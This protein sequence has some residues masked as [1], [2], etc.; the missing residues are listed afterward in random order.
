MLDVESALG[1]IVR[2]FVPDMTLLNSRLGEWYDRNPSHKYQPG[3]ILVQNG[4]QIGFGQRAVA[5]IKDYYIDKACGG[6]Y[7]VE[8]HTDGESTPDTDEIMRLSQEES[9]FKWN[10]EFLFKRVP[11]DMTPNEAVDLYPDTQKG[12]QIP[13]LVEKALSSILGKFE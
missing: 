2:T 13:P 10:M 3:D 7:K 9:H 12:P 8:M 4:P 6:Q 5:I 11:R 1:T